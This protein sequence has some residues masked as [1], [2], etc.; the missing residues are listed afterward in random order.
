MHEKSLLDRGWTSF[1]PSDFEESFKNRLPEPE[2]A[3]MLAVL[4][5][6]LED[7]QDSIDERNCIEKQRF[8]DAEEWIL[9]TDNDWAFS[10]ENICE[11]LQLEPSSIRRR[12]LSWKEAKGRHINREDMNRRPPLRRTRTRPV[13]SSTCNIA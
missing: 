9:N 5:S 6:A 3:L 4:K 13:L 11:A 1:D 12:L 7:F 2:K 8:L 10:F